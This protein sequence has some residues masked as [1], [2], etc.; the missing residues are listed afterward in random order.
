MIAPPT[1]PSFDPTSALIS[2]GSNLVGGLLG[3]K[4]KGPSIEDQ[5]KAQGLSINR[6]WESTMEN[7]AK[8]GVHPTVALG[9]NPAMGGMSFSTGDDGPDVGAAVADLGQN[10]ASAYDRQQSPEQRLTAQVMSRQMVE[11]GEL[12]NELL[13]TQIAQA[14]SAMSPPVAVSNNH[15]MIAGQGD[16]GAEYLA[17]QLVKHENASGKEAGTPAAWT[18]VMTPSGPMTIPSKDF[19]DR[20]EDIPFVGWEWLLKNRV[21]PEVARSAPGRATRWYSDYT[22]KF[23][24]RFVKKGG[25]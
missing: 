23:V 9:V 5:V 21:I 6:Y 13:K 22:D 4:K 10:I 2:F 3:K 15:E 12:E 8:W 7:A 20:A 14:R 25:K 16:T 11:R 19:Q 18:T 24:K 1:G 17:N